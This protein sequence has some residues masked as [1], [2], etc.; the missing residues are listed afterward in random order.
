MERKAGTFESLMLQKRWGLVTT[1]KGQG[2]DILVMLVS[3][4]VMPL[5]WIEHT[6]DPSF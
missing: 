3:G 6:Y 5:S 4:M 1:W 2:M